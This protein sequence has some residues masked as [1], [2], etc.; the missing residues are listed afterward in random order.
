MNLEVTVSAILAGQGAQRI[1][2]SLPFSA[3]VSESVI[4]AFTWIL[5]N[6][7]P[8]SQTRAAST[9]IRAPG[10][11]TLF[12]AFG[13]S[14]REYKAVRSYPS[15]TIPSISS[16]TM[17]YLSPNS[18]SPSSSLSPVSVARMH[19]DTGP[20]SGVCVTYQ[21]HNPIENLPPTAAIINCN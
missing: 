14:S 20:S 2:L 19:T 4:L 18:I 11:H 1:C 5:G 10:R 12:S 15:S 8:G 13:F 7:N 17:L 16:P 6:L 21:G 3:R 9:L